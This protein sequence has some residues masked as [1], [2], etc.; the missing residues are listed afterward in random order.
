MRNLNTMRR[1]VFFSRFSFLL[2]FIIIFFFVQET[3]RL[4]TFT[5]GTRQYARLYCVHRKTDSPSLLASTQRLLTGE[6]RRVLRK[7]AHASRWKHRNGYILSFLQ[8]NFSFVENL[9]AKGANNDEQ[10]NEKKYYIRVTN[11]NAID[12]RNENGKRFERTLSSF[13]RKTRAFHT[14]RALGDTGGGNGGV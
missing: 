4:H 8:G 1:N 6:N 14:R 13:R 10:P 9:I 5:F 11:E 12:G 3:M 7:R 2:C